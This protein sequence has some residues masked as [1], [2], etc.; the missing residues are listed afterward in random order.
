MQ[1]TTQ[2]SD[3]F[4]EFV[5]IIQRLRKECPWD[6]KQT[7][8]SLRHFLVEEAFETSEAISNADFGHL[9]SELGDILLQVVLHSVI[10]E[11]EKRF[12]LTDVID[13][14]TEKMKRRHPHVF[15]NVEA[16]TPEEVLHNWELIK[17]EEGRESILEGIPE[18]APS[19]LRAY[20]IQMKAAKVGFDWSNKDDVWKKVEE[21]V[22]E[23]H[24]AVLTDNEKKVEEEFGD[25]LF[26]LVNYA[27]WLK[28]QP[29]LALQSTVRKFVR[30]FKYIEEE[31][32]K[33][34]KNIGTLSLN[35]MDAFWDAVKRSERK[36]SIQ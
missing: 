14:V 19:L 33:S 32:I 4:K 5:Q 8:F 35:E 9:K 29:E 20:Q 11:E 28:I 12:T 36:D 13:A 34:G 18:S 23:L 31:I 16:E 3:S 26:A 27:R 17:L 6:R 7:H 2:T 24:N 30:R 25:L 22:N 1:N 15:G 10:A 21:E